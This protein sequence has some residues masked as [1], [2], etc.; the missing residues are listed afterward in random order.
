MVLSSIQKDIIFQYRDKS[1]VCS[2]LCQQT[3]DWYNFLISIIN[4]PLILMSTSLSIINSL[5]IDNNN[6]RMTNIIIN[7][8]FALILALINNFNIS[9]KKVNFR[10][11]HLKYVKLT[12]YI[13]DKITNELDN[14]TKEDIRNIINDYDIL[15]ENL[16]YP[17]PGFIRKRVKKRFFGKKTLPNILNCEMI[18]VNKDD[19][20]SLI[21]YLNN[22]ND[23]KVSIIIE[24]NENNN[25]NHNISTRSLF[26]NKIIQ[27]E[28]SNS[29]NIEDKLYK[30]D[31]SEKST[32]PA[33]RPN[34]SPAVRPTKNMISSRSLFGTSMISR[35]DREDREDSEDSEDSEDKEY[36]NNDKKISILIE[37]KSDQSQKEVSPMV[38]NN[39]SPMAVID[40]SNN[41][42][43]SHLKNI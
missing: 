42:D 11:L 41:K 19:N 35:K 43:F 36:N 3:T 13:E 4:I 16:E 6:M 23:R 24:K 38:R 7:A 34:I 31:Y 40:T 21:K 30:D 39:I 1:Y 33:T 20:N 17:Y 12:H 10:S 15:G 22:T 32:S 26:R 2:I 8:S 37:K 14:C 28:N 9:E 27:R 18:F 5:N 29:N 25:I